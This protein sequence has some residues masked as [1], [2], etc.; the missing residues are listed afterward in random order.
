MSV[1][2]EIGFSDYDTKKIDMDMNNVIEINIEIKIRE[3]RELALLSIKSVLAKQCI[4]IKKS[5][6]NGELLSIK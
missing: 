1:L 6:T 2:E 5:E 4:T 3:L